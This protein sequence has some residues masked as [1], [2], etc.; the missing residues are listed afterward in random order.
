[1]SGEHQRNQQETGQP[2]IVIVPAQA[3][4]ATAVV[5][6][7]ET[8]SAIER[9]P[10]I[11]AVPGVDALFLG[12]GDLSAAM[13]RIGEIG[14]PEVQALIE[15]T[16]SMAHA[17]GKP[18]GIVG[19]NPAMVARFLSYGYDFAAVASDMGMMTGR[20]T[21]WLAEIRGIKAGP[22]AEAAY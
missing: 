11:A 20:A 5:I 3:N 9:L 1:M 13:G 2:E 16:A 22:A 8:P 10:E 17:A 21:E 6:Q 19:P 4:A 12:P 15:R 7:L 18:I 14:H